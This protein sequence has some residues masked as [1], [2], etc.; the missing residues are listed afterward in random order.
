MNQEW[1][2]GLSL[3]PEIVNKCHEIGPIDIMVGVLCKNVESTVLSVLN[4]INE[5]LYRY[6]PDYN[7]AIVVSKAP[8]SDNTDEA[9]NLFQPYNSIHTIVTEDIVS[10]GKGSGVMTI[11]EIA[12]EAQ[13]KCIVLMDGDLLSIQ[14]NW[15]QTI[16][17][18]VVY[19]RSD[20]TV[21]YYIRDK[22]DGVITNN[23][24][25][26]FTRSL[27]GIDIRQPIAGEFALSKPLYETLRNHPLLPPDFGIDIFIV[28]TAAAEGYYVKEGLFSLKIHEST[29]HYLE[30]EKFL[31]PMFRKVTGSMFELA[32]YY[33]SY[34]RKK[35]S[36]WKP[37]HH[38]ECFSQH[39]I[40]VNI[41]IEEMN[42]SFQQEFISNKE[43][44][45]KYL[46]ED[47]IANVD[48]VI[49]NGE[50]FSAKLWANI[51]YQYASSFKTLET[52]ADK[53]TLLDT[54]KTLWLGRFVSYAH[55]VDEMDI[56]GAEIIIQKQAEIFEEQFEYLKE[57]Y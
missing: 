12:H 56:N 46:P 17:N 44:M 55:Q 15:I 35:P 6:F 2:K 16:A 52:D 49:N 18:P 25:Y 26:P 24:V 20:L 4:T 54:L 31:I 22:N 14:P 11:F 40:P 7:L 9:I 38:R 28:T 43:Y 34:W 37:K 32:K 47:L 48:H 42:K 19:G 5:G 41:N 1:N 21:P 23:L 45:K 3:N 50:E 27:Y 57:I 30:P 10:G 39:P 8:S 51:V 33:E 13:A 53:Y 36:R 29:T